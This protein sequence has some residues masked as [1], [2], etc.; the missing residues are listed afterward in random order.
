MN[1]EIHE[2]INELNSEDHIIQGNACRRVIKLGPQ[3]AG[4]APKLIQ[5]TGSQWH[6]LADV[7]TVALYNV[8]KEAVP[9]LMQ[10]L[11]KA[12]SIQKVNII[13]TLRRLHESSEEIYPTIGG[14]LKDDDHDVSLQAAHSIAQIV[15]DKIKQGIDIR[16]HFFEAA[17]SILLNEGQDANNSSWILL[18]D[19]KTAALI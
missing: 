18:K 10:Q 5:L 2:I 4:I 16:D 1:D 7:A 6:P 3:A 12:D 9:L 15:Y 11:S 17:L 19:L 13:H 8:G 14:C